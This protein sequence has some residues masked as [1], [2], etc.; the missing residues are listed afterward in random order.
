MNLVVTLEYR[1]ARTPDGKVWTKMTFA[2]RFWQRYLEV[3]ESVRVVARAHEVKEISGDFKRV[4][5]E[6]VSFVEVPFYVGPWQYLLK[7]RQVACAVKGA[8]H[9]KDAVIMRVPSQIAVALVPQLRNTRHPFGLEVVGDPYDVF[10]PGA[11]RH[12]LRPFFRW[13]FSNELRWQ[14]ANAI[15][16]AYVTEYALQRRYPPNPRLLIISLLQFGDE[17]QRHYASLHRQSNLSTH[18]SD[19]ELNRRCIQGSSPALVQGIKSHL[20]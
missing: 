20:S 18:Y 6:S 19:V 11:V 7:N 4:D 9:P 10:A 14:C 13:W 17:R 8:V 3:F 12:P 5:G 16:T 15:G 2:H 1:F